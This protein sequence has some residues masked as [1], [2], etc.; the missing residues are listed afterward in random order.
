MAMSVKAVD[1]NAA[2]RHAVED[3]ACGTTQHRLAGSDTAWLLEHACEHSFT[4]ACKCACVHG[5]TH[6]CM[7]PW[8]CVRT[9]D[10]RPQCSP[11]PWW[12]KKRATGGRTG[13]NLTVY[14]RCP[15]LLTCQLSA[16][17]AAA[18]RLEGSMAGSCAAA[19]PRQPPVPRRCHPP[20]SRAGALDDFVMR[21][22][23]G[24]GVRGRDDAEWDWRLDCAF[25]RAAGGRPPER[26]A[27]KAQARLLT[28]LAGVG[29]PGQL[30]SPRINRRSVHER[31]GLNSKKNHL[32][33]HPR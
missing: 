30:R 27:A 31:H 18:A 13:A 6:V 11:T 19:R 9:H 23:T 3:C 15:R 7:H 1:G 10:K 2:L 20:S 28:R 5:R 33:F 12:K 21:Q 22:R 32:S 14:R 25:G 29:K 8:V 26:S 4:H 24:A 17:P 16:L